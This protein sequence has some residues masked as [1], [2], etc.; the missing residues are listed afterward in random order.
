MSN[1]AKKIFE[2]FAVRVCVQLCAAGGGIVVARAFSLEGKG[3][4]TYA[5]AMLGLILMATVGH[6]KAVLWQYRRLGL[7]PDGVVRAMLLIVAAVST[8][9]VLLFALVGLLI[10]SQSALVYVAAAIP[11]AIFIGS[12]SGIFLADGDV[13]RVNIATILASGSAALVYVPL[14][15]FVHRSLSIA[16]AGWAAGYVAAAIYMWFGLR[17]YRNSDGGYA[18]TKRLVKQQVT[19]GSQACLSSVMQYLAFRIDAFL[20]IYLLGS[21]ALGVYSV[22]LSCG[23]FIWQLS[24]AM[25]NP[26]LLDI[27]GSDRIRA[28]EL[29]AKCVRH[30][31]L[32]VLC[33]AVLVALLARTVVPIIFGP[34]FS[35][36]AV[37]TLALLPGIVAY[38][39]M[40]A[41]AAF[42]LQHLGEPRTPFYFSAL[43]T[44]VCAVVTFFTLPHFGIIAAA[45]A[46]SISYTIAFIA[47]AIYFVRRTGTSVAKIFG[48]SIDDLRPYHVLVSSAF[49]SIRGRS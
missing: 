49:A 34:A 28:V 26:S 36:G 46:T 33:A 4:F 41:L 27:G 10:P 9:L 47:A 32:L 14:I 30:S 11:F 13:R 6:N 16:L 1:I 45:V 31:F 23:E 38:S 40:P 8:P 44:I 20:V 39:M 35:Y 25:I 7:R 43:A 3:A 15:L 19:F 29:T 48:F 17:R 21:A 5:G 2:T 24:N 18:D 42:F 22:G 37:V 12:A